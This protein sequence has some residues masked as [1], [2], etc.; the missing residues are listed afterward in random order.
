MI[1]DM[2]GKLFQDLLKIVNADVQNVK[3]HKI[4]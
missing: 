1:V 4:K 2:N 3:F